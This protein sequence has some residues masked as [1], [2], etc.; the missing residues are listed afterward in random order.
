MTTRQYFTMWAHTVSP[1]GMFVVALMYGMHFLSPRNLVRRLLWHLLKRCQF[2]VTLRGCTQSYFCGRFIEYADLHALQEVFVD[3]AYNLNVVDTEPE[4]VID[5]GAHIGSFSVMVAKRF[6]NAKRI[7]FEPDPENYRMLMANM[8]LNRVH[9]EAH[10]IALGGS[11]HIGILNG[12]SSMGRRLGAKHGPEVQVRRLPSAVDLRSVN[13]L[14][15]KI[16]VEGSEIAI[17]EDSCDDL[18]EDTVIFVETHGGKND[19]DALQKLAIS[20]SFEI[21]ETKNKG[22]L[23]E[24]L[25]LRGRF[26]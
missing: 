8:K 17:L 20:H 7:A 16:D 5:A 22:Q 11:D 1:S 24:Y 19:H 10:Q 14:L 3:N 15:L 9:V 25:L 4:C 6:P 23:A 13:S 21:S 2:Q 12:P 26:R 18:P